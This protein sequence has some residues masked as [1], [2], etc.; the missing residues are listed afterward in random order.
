MAENETKDEKNG[1]SIDY[2]ASAANIAKAKA[3]AADED[4]E[5]LREESE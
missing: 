4:A 5:R 1:G 2:N 3:K